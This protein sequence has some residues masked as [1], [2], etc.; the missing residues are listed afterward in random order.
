MALRNAF[1]STDFKVYGCLKTNLTRIAQKI[2]ENGSPFLIT[3]MIR[4]TVEV[5]QISDIQ[6]AYLIIQDI[7]TISTIKISNKLMTS[8]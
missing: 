3:D 6:D 7:D 5:E 8:V 2:Q 4:A 1:K